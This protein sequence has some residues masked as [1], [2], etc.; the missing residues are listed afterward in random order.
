MNTP[1]MTFEDGTLVLR[2]WDSE[3]PP[4]SFIPDPRDDAW[5]APAYLYAVILEKFRG[6]DSCPEDRAS[7]FD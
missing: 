2:G 6:A 3:H 4:H 7:R 5:R 1:V